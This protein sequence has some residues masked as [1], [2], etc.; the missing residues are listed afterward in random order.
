M[1]G[2]L[3][4]ELYQ[5]I[6]RVD[7][8][9]LQNPAMEF[10]DASVMRTYAWSVV[11]DRPVCW[12]CQPQNWPAELRPLVLASQP[13]MSRRL[14]HDPGVR[15]FLL[16]L[17]AALTGSLCLQRLCLC[18]LM[19]G[20]PLPVGRYSKDPDA[21]VGHGAGGIDRGYKAHVLW[22][23]APLPIWEVRPMNIAEQTVAL[24]LIARTGHENGGYVLADCGYDSSR[25]HDRCAAHGLQLL[26]P[27]QRPRGAGRGHCVQ[28]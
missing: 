14:K 16:E 17:E 5:W 28:N 11:H 7:K 21:A 22:H 6:D 26:A 27:A 1:D 4:R 10:S 15:Q 24:R 25:V 2:E 19:D 23:T 12:A 8:A 9:H 3:W 13:T 18:W 20:K